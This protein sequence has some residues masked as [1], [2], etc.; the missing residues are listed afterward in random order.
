M[1]N[2]MAYLNEGMSVS[3]DE[4]FLDPAIKVILYTSV[5]KNSIIYNGKAKMKIDGKILALGEF[6][7]TDK[8]RDI[9]IRAFKDNEETKGYRDQLQFSFKL[10]ERALNFM[11]K[12]MIFDKNHKINIKFEFILYVIH[13]YIQFVPILEASTSTHDL[14]IPKD[15]PL[16]KDLSYIKNIAKEK[17]PDISSISALY[18]VYG[19]Y[20]CNTNMKLLLS[21]ENSVSGID[22]PIL[23][24]DEYIIT[25]DKDIDQSE[26][27]EEYAKK[28][29]LRS[30]V[31]IAIPKPSLNPAN[32]A[33][34]EALKALKEAED[35]LYNNFNVGSALSALRNSI[36]KYNEGLKK[37][38]GGPD[39][40][41]SPKEEDYKK[42]FPN[43][44][45]SVL[46]YNLQQS[47]YEIGSKNDDYGAPHQ[48]SEY[49]VELYEVES[50]IYMAYNI[51][52]I[53]F[54]SINKKNMPGNP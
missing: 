37:L 29:G 1:K 16:D 49:P 8:N 5:E 31:F 41:K 14:E 9:A 30:Y 53:T 21:R 34:D 24:R 20:L 48:N 46:I 50:M 28:L 52:R 12:K 10:T 15:S 13:S 43:K 25:A 2:N 22:G 36:N 26:W 11:E 19:H 32:D 40:K 33:F 35:K 27:V 17:W 3:I 18:M 51:F 44:D 38:I 6:V 42:I 47:I 39:V 45:I 4:D 23:A 54:E 7:D